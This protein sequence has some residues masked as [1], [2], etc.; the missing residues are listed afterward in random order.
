MGRDGTTI[1]TP[2]SS[3]PSPPPH[4]HH[5]PHHHHHPV[6]PSPHHHVTPSPHHHHHPVTPSPYHHHHP[7]TPTSPPSTITITVAITMSVTA[8]NTS[9][10]TTYQFPSSAMPIRPTLEFLWTQAAPRC[11]AM[12]GPLSSPQPHAQARE[13]WKA[14]VLPGPTCPQGPHCRIRTYHLVFQGSLK[15]QAPLAGAPAIDHHHGVAQGRQSVQPKVLDAFEGV[16]HQL[17][18]QA[19]WVVRAAGV[20]GGRAWARVHPPVGPHRQRAQWGASFLAAG[21][22]ACRSCRRAARRRG[23]ESGKS[24]GA[25]SPGDSLW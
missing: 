1:T 13:E 2:P 11:Q 4:H 23:Y 17:H 22:A 19:R 8:L 10:P 3:P 25:R 12:S 9:V 5:A 24:P 15:S 21:C 6:T 7:I 16:G 18:L 20:A 14:P